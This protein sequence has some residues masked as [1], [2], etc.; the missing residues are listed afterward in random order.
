MLVAIS[1]PIFTAQLEKS[2]EATD[3]ANL[4]SIYAS[5]SSDVIMGNTM[6]E[7]SN[8]NGA[9]TYKIE[10]SGD[11]YTGTA[12]YTMKQ[13]TDGTASGSAVD[14]GGVSITSANFKKGTC[15]IV[16]K[17]DGTDPTFTW[18]TT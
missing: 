18:P 17:S 11:V 2:R 12:T 14:I 1:I 8:Y 5:L 16:V 15:T 7:K 9:T 6:A 4:R 13:Q 10:N 3:E